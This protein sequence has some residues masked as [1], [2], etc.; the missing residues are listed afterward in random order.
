MVSISIPIKPRLMPLIVL[1]TWRLLSFPIAPHNTKVV[2]AT[3]RETIVNSST[4]LYAT[5]VLRLKYANATW[6]VALARA[7][8]AVRRNADDH[9]RPDDR[10][11][12]PAIDPARSRL[13]TIQ[14][15]L[16]CQCVPDSIRWRVAPRRPPWRPAW[17]QAHPY[18]G[19]GGIHRGVRAARCGAHSPGPDRCSIP[20]GRR[21]RHSLRVDSGN[22][23]RHVSCA[24]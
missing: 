2:G 16:G 1:R 14:P 10:Q 17:P 18:F 12:R 8:R 4:V 5:T 13:L 7:R 21:R 15:R 23:R 19:A 3:I 24:A 9:S 20:G 6:S 11:R 22:D